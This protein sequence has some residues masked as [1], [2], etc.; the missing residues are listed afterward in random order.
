MTIQRVS[1]DHSE[2]VDFGNNFTKFTLIISDNPRQLSSLHDNIAIIAMIM[3]MIMGRRGPLERIDHLQARANSIQRGEEA[4][5]V[6]LN[7]FFWGK[8]HHDNFCM[9]FI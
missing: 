7:I 3:T 2:N 8:N 5:R 4:N 6:I 1:T 9:K